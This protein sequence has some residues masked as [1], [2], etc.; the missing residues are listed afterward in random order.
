MAVATP[1]LRAP[2]PRIDEAATTEVTAI[3]RRHTHSDAVL[4]SVYL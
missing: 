1:G 4:P 3:L 2:S